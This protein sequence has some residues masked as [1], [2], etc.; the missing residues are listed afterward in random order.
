MAEEQEEEGGHYISLSLCGEEGMDAKCEYG[1]A[2]WGFFSCI[3][4]LSFFL[5]LSFFSFS[6]LFF[7]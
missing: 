6:F 3:F 5:T 1:V 2:V 7:S 4:F